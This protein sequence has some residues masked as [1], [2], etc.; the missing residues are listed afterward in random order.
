M[1]YVEVRG[2]LKGISVL[3]LPCGFQGLNLGH[4]TWQQGMLSDKPSH[5]ACPYCVSTLKKLQADKSG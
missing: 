1:A 4:Q 5:W 2:Q 3:L